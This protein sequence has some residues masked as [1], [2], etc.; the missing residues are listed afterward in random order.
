M[1]AGD[2]TQRTAWDFERNAGRLHDELPQAWNEGTYRVCGRLMSATPIPTAERRIR[3]CIDSSVRSIDRHL[4]RFLFLSKWPP[5]LN[6]AVA[7]ML[8]TNAVYYQGPYPMHFSGFLLG[9]RINHHLIEFLR[10]RGRYDLVQEIAAARGI[11][12]S[13]AATMADE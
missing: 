3:H 9:G 2:P 10:A 13:R 7:K 6:R 12:P 11:E 4:E 5:F 1:S 8:K